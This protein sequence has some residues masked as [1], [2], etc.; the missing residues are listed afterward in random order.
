MKRCLFI[1]TELCHKDT[2]K[3]W[4]KKNSGENSC[5]GKAM[6]N[7]FGQVCGFPFPLLTL[8]LEYLLL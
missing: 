7:Y 4:L 5:N 2:L 8:E 6:V 3:H 1:L